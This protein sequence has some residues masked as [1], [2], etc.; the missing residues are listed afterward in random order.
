MR[1]QR[2][3]VLRQGVSDL[4]NVLAGKVTAITVRGGKK[5][6]ELIAEM[7][8]TGFQARHLAAV[9]DV[10]EEMIKNPNLTILLGYAGSMSTTT[11]SLVYAFGSCAGDANGVGSGYTTLGADQYNSSL[12]EYKNP[13][14]TSEN[15]TFPG[16]N[17]SGVWIAQAIAIKVTGTGIAGAKLTGRATLSGKATL[18]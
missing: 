18:H 4:D 10:W 17:G 16:A 3:A 11:G 15:A 1:M 6:S 8:N 14:G 5:L 9:V 2:K 13:S 7:G 12:Q